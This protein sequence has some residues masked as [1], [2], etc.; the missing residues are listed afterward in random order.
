[1]AF[2]ASAQFYDVVYESKDYAG[3]IRLVSKIIDSRLNSITRI[4]D[5][6]C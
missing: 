5:V 6:V 2:D 3:E 1:M 4:L